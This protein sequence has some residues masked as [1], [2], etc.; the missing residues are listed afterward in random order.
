[1]LVRLTT[2][3][4]AQE[5]L[6]IFIYVVDAHLAPQGF[7]ILHTSLAKTPTDTHTLS[8]VHAVVSS[9]A[10]NIPVLPVVHRITFFR[11]PSTSSVR[12]YLERQDAAKG[13]TNHPFVG[14][15]DPKAKD[16]AG[17]A[18]PQAPPGFQERTVRCDVG[19]LATC[20]Y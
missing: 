4:H 1:M 12:R 8:M 2:R 16:G 20:R 10:I 17:A 6:C 14:F 19:Y 11:E 5:A 15:S 9:S 18:P 3:R 7:V 13:S